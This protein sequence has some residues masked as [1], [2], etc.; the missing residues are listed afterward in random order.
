MKTTSIGC[1]YRS[2]LDVL[3]D[4]F[5]GKINLARL[6]LFVVEGFCKVKS[7]KYD[8]LSFV[9]DVNAEKKCFN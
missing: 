6:D 2:F 3:Q 9:L 4:Y 8:W 5:Q 7:V 1:K